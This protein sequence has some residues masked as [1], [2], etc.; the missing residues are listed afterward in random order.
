MKRRNICLGLLM[1][2]LATWV[3]RLETGSF[4]IAPPTGTPSFGEEIYTFAIRERNE[5]RNTVEAPPLARMEQSPFSTPMV[6][7]ADLWG[8][9]EAPL[10]PLFG[11]DRACDLLMCLQP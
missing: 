8:T 4:L 10:A 6:T 5:S 7:P 3:D 1:L 2:L 11:G 9:L